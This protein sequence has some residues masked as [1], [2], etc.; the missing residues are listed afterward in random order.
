MAENLKTLNNRNRGA[1][2]HGKVPPASGVKSELYHLKTS[3]SLSET[4]AK[5]SPLLSVEKI[6]FVLF[7]NF[8]ICSST[9]SVNVLFVIS[10][11]SALHPTITASSPPLQ[12]PEFCICQN[13]STIS[14]RS[15][16]WAFDC[17]GQGLSN[18]SITV[19]SDIKNH[20]LSI[21]V[22]SYINLSHNILMS[23]KP[24][25]SE[26]EGHN[27]T[28]V[29]NVLVINMSNNQIN[30]IQE[31][32]LQS[33]REVTALDLSHNQL[34]YIHERA[35]H[36]LHTLT[37]LYL[38]H[39]N[40]SW[41]S[42]G[43]LSQLT[44]LQVLDVSFNNINSQFLMNLTPLNQ[45]KRLDINNNNIQISEDSNEKFPSLPHLSHL[46]VSNN[47]LTKMPFNFFSQLPN[48]LSLNVANSS[49]DEFD[50]R[51]LI[52]VARLEKLNLNGN[53]F[54]SLSK[55]IHLSTSLKWLSIALM[56]R[57]NKIS[58]VAFRGLHQLE[59]LNLSSNP[60]LTLLQH[61]LFS[62]LVALKVLDLSNSGLK[63]L[64]QLSFYKNPELGQVF[65][66]NNPL[67]C[68]CIN[69]WLAHEGNDSIIVDVIS[70]RCILENGEVTDFK[71]AEI[72]CQDI[73]INNVTSKMNVQLG[74]QLKLQCQYESVGPTIIEWT[75]PSGEKFYHHHMS[76]NDSH[77]ITA[78]DIRPNSE[79]HSG[80]F[81]HRSSS[82]HS[83]ISSIHNRIVVLADGSLFIDYMMRID[84]GIYT[85]QVSNAQYNQSV[86][87]NI[88]LICK[89]SSEIKIFAIIAGLLCAL[90]FFMLNLIYVI[91]SWTARRLVNKR[92]REII[93]QMLENL[94]MYKTSQITRIHENY[95]HQLARVRNQYHIQRDKLHRNYTS[96]VAKVKRGCSNQVEKVRDNYNS[97]L[98]QL[99]DYS[100]NQIIQIRERANNQ[101]IR[102]RD[103]GSSQLDKLRETYKLQQQHVL[104]LLDTM[105]LDNCRHVVETECMRTESMM[106]D[107][108]LLGDE[109]RTDSPLSQLDSEY[110][111]AASSPATSL[112]ENSEVGFTRDMSGHQLGDLSTSSSEN[113][114]IIEMQTTIELEPNM[115]VNVADFWEFDPGCEHDN[116]HQY[117]VKVNDQSG[118]RDK[119]LLEFKS[120]DALFHDHANLPPPH[121]L[122][123][124]EESGD[125][126]HFD[127]Q[128]DE[129]WEGVYV[130]PDS[131]PT[132][133]GARSNLLS[134]QLQMLTG[135]EFCHQNSPLNS[136]TN[137]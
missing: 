7:Q 135:Q 52:E 30:E 129:Y 56:P 128:N 68:S 49:L 59:Y 96:Q 69:A 118:H 20:E 120:K 101:I 12:C 91:I 122:E 99:R 46:D 107:I 117:S 39:N 48:L 47:P 74:S 95:T 2:P 66:Q 81:W 103:Y 54:T 27:L 16:S 43:T 133:S 85:C 8:Q 32:D 72:Q 106:F 131:S 5:E 40:I 88:L 73:R 17:S 127:T 105:N 34:Q 37:D 123:M 83:E 89:L 102:I 58:S 55:A 78:Q 51:A 61:D 110:T 63:S 136:E 38:G 65:L 35:M 15:S 57:L 14:P 41:M 109:D 45:L 121:A 82:Y 50:A 71:K 86:R 130:T 67:E 10:L 6:V 4:Q 1:R 90:T 92:R 119:V 33:Y 75:T 111:T 53:N 28:S 94:N 134:Q 64:S 115:S 116:N 11:L 18:I 79:F 124:N 93:S 114:I 112:E 76:P 132:K 77:H 125:K 36:N 87:I 97:K 98:S 108:D 21:P 126:R 9:H 104:K 62:S 22:L 70:L 31:D 80:H 44:Q 19:S 113:A 13:V 23:V 42:N 137:V 24:I 84:P 26:Q 29:I 60:Q 25:Q 3:L 100:S